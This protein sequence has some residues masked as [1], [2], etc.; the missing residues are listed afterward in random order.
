MAGGFIVLATMVAIG[1]G[2]AKL[3]IETNKD[4]RFKK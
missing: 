1:V 2:F 3:G 4:N